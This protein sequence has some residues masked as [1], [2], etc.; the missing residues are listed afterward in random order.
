[1]S[2]ASAPE[3][4][5]SRMRARVVANAR[6][7][8]NVGDSNAPSAWKLG[9][10]TVTRATPFDAAQALKRFSP[11][12]S[13][14]SRKLRS[15]FAQSGHQ[16]APLTA[17]SVYASP[18]AWAALFVAASKSIVHSPNASVSA[19][20]S[21][22]QRGFSAPFARAT[23]VTVRVSCTSPPASSTASVSVSPSASKAG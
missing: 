2:A 3:A 18:S 5:Y 4:G 23:N 15:V 9:T 17:T 10:S 8:R 21:P 1:M 16:S 6:R 13:A 11:S 12:A 14:T 22:I 20:R 19:V 7:D